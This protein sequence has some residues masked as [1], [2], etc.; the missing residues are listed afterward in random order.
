MNFSS[1]H[2][3]EAR[4]ASQFPDLGRL[5]LLLQPGQK[6]CLQLNEGEQ[7]SGATCK[8]LFKCTLDPY[9]YPMGKT[10]HL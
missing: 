8:A 10:L 3:Q 7:G 5:D 9:P 4:D 6:A 2:P 1:T